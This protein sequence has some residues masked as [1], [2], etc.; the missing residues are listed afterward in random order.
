MNLPNI[1]P[2]GRLSSRLAH[3]QNELR[4]LRPASSPG[5]ATSQTTH[6]TVRRPLNTSGSATSSNRP[7]WG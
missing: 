5:I 1:S 4:R 3:L 2:S 6:G 7:K